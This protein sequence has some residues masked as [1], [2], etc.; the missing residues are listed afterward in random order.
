MNNKVIS[1]KID[2]VVN[3][4]IVEKKIENSLLKDLTFL[5]S[6]K[7]ILFIY[8]ENI[9]N[10]FIKNVLEQIKLSGGSII[11][12]KVKGTKKKQKYKKFTFFI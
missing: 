11:I 4:V 12:Q 2:N 5:E 9:D 10:K 3:K 1:Y 8:D 7:K 6:D